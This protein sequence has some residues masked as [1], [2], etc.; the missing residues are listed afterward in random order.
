MLPDLGT[1]LRTFE[2]GLLGTTTWLPSAFLL[3]RAAFWHLTYSGIRTAE[4]PS[5]RTPAPGQ[6]DDGYLGNLALTLMYS[7]Q[8]ARHQERHKS[9]EISIAVTGILSFPS[10]TAKKGRLSLESATICDW[11]VSRDLRASYIDGNVEME[12]SIHVFTPL[13]SKEFSLCSYM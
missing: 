9:R 11:A 8:V 10:P 3:I 6:A 4:R 5:I 12:P 1:T 7:S 13:S 2:L